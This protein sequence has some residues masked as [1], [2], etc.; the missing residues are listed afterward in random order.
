MRNNE[1]HH[2]DA[3]GQFVA[4]PQSPPPLTLL[5][6][7]LTAPPREKLASST[8]SLLFPHTY[9]QSTRGVALEPNPRSCPVL[10]VCTQAQPQAPLPALSQHGYYSCAVKRSPSPPSPLLVCL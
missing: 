9:G 3:C 10:L 4:L 6:P 7:M 1:T 5:F 2:L 8:P